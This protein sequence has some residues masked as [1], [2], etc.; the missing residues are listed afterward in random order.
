MGQYYL[1]ANMDK[2]SIQT[3]T[4]DEIRNITGFSWL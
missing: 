4:I 1:I 2:R 3:S